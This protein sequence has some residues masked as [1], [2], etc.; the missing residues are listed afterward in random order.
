MTMTGSSG[1]KGITSD[2][3]FSP[4]RR[5]RTKGSLYVASSTYNCFGLHDG[6]MSG[7]GNG[8]EYYFGQP[9]ELFR[10]TKVNVSTN[11]SGTA[12]ANTHI[13]EI[14][15]TSTNAKGYIDDNL[16]KENTTTIPTVNLKVASGLYG[17]A[18]RVQMDWVFLGKFLPPEP[19]WGSWRAEE[20][21]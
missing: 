13:Y 16:W 9:N 15:W 2:L 1:W 20:T 4:G 7:I 12:D 3:T 18:G 5:W 17:G 6:I 11:N 19:T 8:V 10:T 21:N 14:D